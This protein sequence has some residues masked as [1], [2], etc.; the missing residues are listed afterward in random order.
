[1]MPPVEEIEAKDRPAARR[2][3]A[4]PTPLTRHR[5]HRRLRKPMKPKKLRNHRKP[6][7]HIKR[8]AQINSGRL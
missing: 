6:M 7:M 4:P 8:A 2:A 1:M 5:N 3:D